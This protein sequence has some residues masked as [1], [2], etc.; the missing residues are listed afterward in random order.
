MRRPSAAVLALS[1]LALGGCGSEAIDWAEVR[2]QNACEALNPAF[3]PGAYGF[4]V[5]KDG[6]F[7]VGPAPSGAVETGVVTAE[8]QVRIASDVAALHDEDVLE[9]DSEPSGIPGATNAVDVVEADGPTIRV[10][11]QTLTLCT[12]GGRA[13]AAQLH[14]DMTA[15]LVKYSPRPFPP[16]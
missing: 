3:C 5:A 7:R 13:A 4:T 8:E 10:Y 14:D 6:A 15:L 16:S 2:Q 9:C 1:L 11:E 12:R